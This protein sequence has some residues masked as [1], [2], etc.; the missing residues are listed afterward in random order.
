MAII[1]AVLRHPCNFVTLS[2]YIFVL[3]CV[4]FIVHAAFVR[5]K[6]MT[7]MVMMIKYSCYICKTM[8]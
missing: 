1:P 8:L 4:H 6:L 5:I 7:T 2:L 3:L